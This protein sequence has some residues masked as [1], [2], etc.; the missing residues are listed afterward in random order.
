MGPGIRHETGFVPV[1]CR[2]RGLGCESIG[3]DN[4]WWEELMLH[5]SPVPRAERRFPID[6][7]PTC[8]GVGTW[9][10]ERGMEVRPVTWFENIDGD[11]VETP[12][13]EVVF[14]GST[15]T[16]R[17]GMCLGTGR[18]TF[19][20]RV[21]RRG[22]PWARGTEGCLRCSTS[23]VFVAAHETPYRHDG[24]RTESCHP[25]C[26]R[27]WG[28]LAVEERLG[29]YVQHCVIA[30]I[31]SRSWAEIVVAVRAGG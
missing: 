5:R 6:P 8:D 29:F 1:S 22:R 2:V 12:G 14:T 7:C 9:P 15:E 13:D 3:T 27:C 4:G 20:A 11:R 10:Y 19:G 18:T 26:K 25:L 28:D 21:G 24:K 30:Q 23:F 17:C 16:V 31:D